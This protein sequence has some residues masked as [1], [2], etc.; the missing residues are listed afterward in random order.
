LTFSGLRGVVT[1]KYSSVELQICMID[2][3]RQQLNVSTAISGEI[4]ISVII[5]IFK[6][7]LFQT[8][9]FLLKILQI[10]KYVCCNM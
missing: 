10:R 9:Q 7:F 5:L 3:Y 8:L 1:Q 2:N 6:P 4:F